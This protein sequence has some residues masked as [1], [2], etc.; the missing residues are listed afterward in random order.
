MFYTKNKIDQLIKDTFK[1]QE[2]IMN[3]ISNIQE[4]L[5]MQLEMNKVLRL[6]IEK[7][8]EENNEQHIQ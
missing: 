7:L 4:C 3:L 8:E 6:R 1:N 2:E 5:K